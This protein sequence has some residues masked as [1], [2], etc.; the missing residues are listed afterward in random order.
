MS[1]APLL[2]LKL[3]ARE[4]RSG[5]LAVLLLALTVAVGAL[6]G[7]GFLVNRIGQS[8]A[9][10]AN[11][12][13]AADLRLESSRPLPATYLDEANRRGLKTANA[14]SVLSVVFRDDLNQLA[15]LRAVSST[16]PLRGTVG[17]A[18]EAFGT[19]TAVDSGPPRG[20][21][22]PD[23]KLLAAL[24]AKLGDT[25]SVGAATFLISKVL[26]TRP[27]QGGGFGELAPSLLMHA[28]DLPATRLLQP[29]S[30]ATYAALFAGEREQ[31]AA[32]KPWLAER[33][34]RGERL[35]D[36]SEASPQIQNAID[37]AGRFLSLASLVA[38]LLCAIAVG[39]SARRYVQ[40]HLDSVALLKTLGASRAFTLTV[41][42]VQLLVIALAAAA[43]GSAIGYLAQEWLLR[44]LQGLL[45]ADLPPPDWLPFGLGLATAVALLAGFALPPLL[46]LSTVPAIRV[47]RRDIAPPKPAIWLAFGPA[48]A[49]IVFLIYWVVRDWVFFFG[50]VIGLTVF[51]AVLALAGWLL[52]KGAGGLRGTVGVSWRYGIANL[53]RRRTES[54]VQIVAF[55]LGIMVLLVLAVVR[56]DLLTDWRR[57]LPADLPNFFFINIPPTER[58]DFFAFLKERGAATSRELPMIRARLTEL[59]G[60]PV[61]TIEFADPRGEG[62]ARRDQ[63]IT[64]QAA[65]G[66]DNQVVAGRWWSEADH[67]RALVS[68]SDE[69]QQGLGLSVGDRMTF[70]IAGEVIEAEVAS[71][72]K[73]KWDSFQ[74]NFFVVFPPGLL[75]ELAGTWMTSAYFKP[76]D[77]RVISELVRRFPSVSVFDL[78]DLLEQVRGVIDKAVLAVQSVFLFTLFAGLTVLL[79]A[80]QA[81]RDERRYESAMLR[82]LGAS[83][84]VVLRGLLAEFSALGLLSGLLAAT[85]ASIAGFFL[86]QQVLQVSYEF[87]PEVW[88]VGTLG[89]AALVA[90]AG[91]LATRNVLRQPPATSLR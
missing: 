13:L 22:W 12:V 38:V 54:I 89:G 85:G 56:N 64:W 50:F 6:T 7:V 74:P 60:K 9:L 84:S 21:A 23:S 75:D 68:I 61:E 31:V 30:R 11:E 62:Y 49:A 8:V 3:L 77:G 37:R 80:V 76:G 24:D 28:D 39:M 41:S 87:S 27:D 90:V 2:G 73:I 82:T 18:T 91:W 29:G 33:K 53:G 47:L 79:A 52:V 36:V 67:G 4:W 5:E 19:P 70:D 71:V 34:Q 20:E 14:T 10:Q 58:E 40:R 48:I 72:R 44:A 26:I 1:R 51:T 43:V 81:T 55:G 83:R 15:N 86:A 65:L 69:Y 88:L 66:D 17:V 35:R 59:N 32:F 78:D 45:R 57:S 46:Q 42:L 63:N 16:Y 25:V